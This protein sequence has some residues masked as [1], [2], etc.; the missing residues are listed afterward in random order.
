[1]SRQTKA[2]IDLDAI[3]H[4]YQ[5]AQK[6]AKASENIAVIK[7][8]A[9]GHGAREVAIKLEPLVK[10]FAVAIFEEAVEL[11]SAGIHKPILILQGI[12]S[13]DEVVYAAENNC[14]LMVHQPAQIDILSDPRLTNL[15]ATIKLW[16]KVDT[17]MHRLGF[18]P[19][20]VASTLVQL[21]SLALINKELVLCSHFSHASDIQHNKNRRQLKRFDDL[22]SELKKNKKLTDFKL[23][24]S[25]AN[26]PAIAA[27]P[28]S[29]YEWNRP[30]IMLYGVGLFDIP[31][32]TDRDLKP[33]MH[34]ISSIIA[35]RKIKPGQSVGYGGKW[36]AQRATLIATVAV[37]YADGYPRQVDNNSEVFVRGRRA[38]VVGTVSMDMI[39]VDVTDITDVSTGD[40][41]E[42]WGK[43]IMANVV[44]QQA[45]TI[46]Y[47]LLTSV[48][49]RV[50]REY[51]QSSLEK[52]Q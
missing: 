35:L 24:R 10:A 50:P 40:V 33:A 8:N 31:H 28:A 16:L 14:W 46:G 6:W 7:A 34:F 20:N 47:H 21:S 42:L 27:L 39:T 48:S 29:H 45:S 18:N 32:V 38:P 2:I 52:T 19:E 1:M 5:L 23:I 44:A 9:Y 30:G 41:V 17:G 36:V 15:P 43:N 11:R 49:A 3:A 22:F 4:N 51:V 25:M 13:V 26:S 12:N 37:G